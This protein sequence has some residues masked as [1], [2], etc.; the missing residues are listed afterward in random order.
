LH[1]VGP[2]DEYGDEEDPTQ[3]MDPEYDE[4]AVPEEQ[5]NKRAAIEASNASTQSDNFRLTKH[6]KELRKF[7]PSYTTGSFYIFSS[8]QFALAIND[9]AVTLLALEAN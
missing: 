4:M 8:A 5:I 9:G 7:E 6:L 2:D 1:I 3:D